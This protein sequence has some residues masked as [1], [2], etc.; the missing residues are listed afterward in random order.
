[1]TTSLG[2]FEDKQYA[3]LLPLTALHPVWD[4]RCGIFTLGEKIERAYAGATIR[5]NCR[6]SLAP[7][8]QE[9]H[10]NR[11]VN[12]LPAGPC[13]F[14]NGRLLADPGITTRIPLTGPDT[15]YTCGPVIV[16]VRASRE[17]LRSIT[18]DDEGL[19][20]FSALSG[21][22]H[23]ETA[24]TLVQYPWEIVNANGRWITADAAAFESAPSRMEGAVIYQGAHLL[25]PGAITIGRGSTIKPGVVLDAENGPIVIGANVRI[26]PNAVIEGPAYIGDGSLVKIGAKI[27]EN[28]SIGPV[29]KVG[30]EV[31]G[32]ILHGYA[33]KQHDGFLGHSY[34]CPW[35]NLGADTNNSDLKNNYSTVRVTINGTEINSGSLFAGLIMGDHAKSG[36]NTMFNTGT[37]VGVGSNVFGSGFPPKYIPAFSWGGSE[38]METYEIGKCI[39]VARTVMQ[40]RSRTLTS[41]AEAAM[42][43][44]F[45]QTVNERGR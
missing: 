25:N 13:L 8:V 36:I 16:G 23:T 19:L 1:M 17:T 35:V 18:Q 10:P 29:C 4:I 43:H 15:V 2:I 3:S 42:R 5:L 22:P 31:E 39:A 27:Y 26:F 30:G 9:E 28:T 21:L 34:L 33:N 41:A 44:L 11:P 40:R 12:A 14:L 20:D 32:C 6:T 37:V 38:G 7:L 24:C 45:T